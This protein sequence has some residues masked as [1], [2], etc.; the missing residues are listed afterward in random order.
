MKPYITNNNIL[1]TDSTLKFFKMVVF[2]VPYDGPKNLR[3]PFYGDIAKFLQ[4]IICVAT[5][6]KKNKRKAAIKE[7][8]KWSYSVPL[9]FELGRDK[10]PAAFKKKVNCRLLAHK[11]C[12]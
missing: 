12:W 1:V 2:S 9:P 8:K 4:H 10:L 11:S 3:R 6:S 5:C 7:G